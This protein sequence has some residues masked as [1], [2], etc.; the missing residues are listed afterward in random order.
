MQGCV[1]STS[2][3]CMLG[4]CSLSSSP[5]SIVLDSTSHGL[6]QEDFAGF[7]CSKLRNPEMRSVSCE[8]YPIG[9]ATLPLIGE[10]RR[11]YRERLLRDS[12]R[13]FK[14][15]ETHVEVLQCGEEDEGNCQKTSGSFFRL[16][17]T[18][19]LKK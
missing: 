4:K 18:Y 10:D 9:L 7:P 5:I 14:N 17:L 16:R 19:R 12:D 15:D 1:A 6:N 8:D 11:W 2:S 13:L 3:S